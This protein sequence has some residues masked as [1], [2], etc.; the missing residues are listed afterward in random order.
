[1]RRV[2]IAKIASQGSLRDGAYTDVAEVSLSPSSGLSED[3]PNVLGKPPRIRQYN[4]PIKKAVLDV[5]RKP[6][7]TVCYGIK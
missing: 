2:H 3:M 5:S 4:E 1:M 7:S 6:V